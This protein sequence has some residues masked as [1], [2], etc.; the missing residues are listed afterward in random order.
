MLTITTYL[1]RIYAHKRMRLKARLQGIPGDHSIFFH[2]NE[3]PYNRI[4]AFKISS[5]DLRISFHIAN[6]L[7]IRNLIKI[8]NGLYI[9]AIYRSSGLDRRIPRY[10]Q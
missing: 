3:F 7:Y 4:F 9:E 1:S 2:L 8:W 10:C 6:I 5:R